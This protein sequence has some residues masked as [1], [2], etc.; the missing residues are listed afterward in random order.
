MSNFMKI[1]PVGTDL[2]H[3]DGRTDMTKLTVDFHNF[4][5][6]LKNRTP[7]RNFF[8]CRQIQN[9]LHPWKWTQSHVSTLPEISVIF[10]D[11]RKFGHKRDGQTTTLLVTAWLVRQ[12]ANERQSASVSQELLLCIPQIR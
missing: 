1:R 12:C 5:N 10:L 7:F 2:F 11:S 8:F 9:K 4:A 6:A 3:S